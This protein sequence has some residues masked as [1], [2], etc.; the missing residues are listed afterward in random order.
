MGTSSEA[1]ILV[2][3]PSAVSYQ[4]SGKQNKHATEGEAAIY[5]PKIRRRASETGYA[6]WIRQARETISLI[7][8]G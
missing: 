4:P 6:P 2:E 5:D 8:D 1:M 7:A 3:E